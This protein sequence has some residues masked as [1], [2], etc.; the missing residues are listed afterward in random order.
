M[1]DLKQMYGIPERSPP[2]RVSDIGAAAH[3]KTPWTFWNGRCGMANSPPRK[4]RTCLFEGSIRPT[5]YD[6]AEVVSEPGIN[7]RNLLRNGSPDGRVLTTE[8]PVDEA[9]FSVAELI[10]A[11]H[12]ACQCLLPDASCAFARQRLVT[13][14]ANNI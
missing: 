5:T 10:V 4:S 11:L 8:T 1:A 13:G 12:E 6:W 2:F 14:G 3:S 9:A 7:P